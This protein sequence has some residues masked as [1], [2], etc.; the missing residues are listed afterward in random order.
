MQNT[1]IFSVIVWAL[2]AGFFAF[3]VLSHSL[4]NPHRTA[5]IHW[6]F[7]AGAVGIGILGFFVVLNI[8]PSPKSVIGLVFVALPAFVC[9]LLL[10][11][12]DI[13]SKAKNDKNKA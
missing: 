5:F 4:Q 7:L 8:S 6:C 3:V 13:V 11:L 10:R 1:D 2:I 12:Q 9:G